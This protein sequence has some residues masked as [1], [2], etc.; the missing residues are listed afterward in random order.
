MPDS[1]KNDD[2]VEY[3]DP[4]GLLLKIGGPRNY[5]PAEWPDYRTTFGL[6]PEHIPE[7][8]RLAC[9]V[10]LNQGDPD[11]SAVW[12]PLHAWRALGQLRAEASVPP[13]LAVLREFEDDESASEE[14]PVVFG[15][16][17]QSAM[18]PIAGFLSGGALPVMSAATATGGLKEIA[19]RHPECRG[20]CVGVLVEMVNNHVQA[21][22]SINGF[23]VSALIDMAAV[24]AIEAI[25]NA[26]RRNWVD[27]S[28]CGDVEDVEVALGLRERRSTPA[29]IYHLMPMG[30]LARPDANRIHQDAPVPGHSKVGRN[31]PCPCGSGK[32]YKKCC[33]Q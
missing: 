14:L 28:I 5:D 4:V 25:R 1:R 12:A 21:D 33:L 17:G 2:R 7:L 31:D 11:S 32:K 23:A 27:I 22:P 24:E 20:D 30:A 29:P 9:D 8:I 15:M 26:F 3:S 10:A 16:I 19:E 6:G 18:A 13:L